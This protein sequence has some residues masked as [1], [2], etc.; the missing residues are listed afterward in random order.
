MIIVIFKYRITTFKIEF[1]HDT[2]LNKELLNIELLLIH[3]WLKVL[4]QNKI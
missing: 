4:L 1:K 3:I 2:Q